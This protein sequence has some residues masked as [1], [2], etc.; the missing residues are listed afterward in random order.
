LYSIFLYL[1]INPSKYFNFI[2]F[3]KQALKTPINLITEL[4]NTEEGTEKLI[5]IDAV[6]SLCSYVEKENISLKFKKAALWIL[7]KICNNKFF[8]FSK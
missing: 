2:T 5:E 8:I 4:S 7:A 6:S 3:R 1:K